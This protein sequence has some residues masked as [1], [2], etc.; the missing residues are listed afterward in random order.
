MRAKRWLLSLVLFL[1][2][3]FV[4]CASGFASAQDGGRRRGDRGRRNEPRAE[5]RHRGNQ[6]SHG[7]IGDYHWRHYQGPQYERRWF[8]R[9]YRD[10]DGYR[11][12]MRWLYGGTWVS[13]HQ[14]ISARRI[15]HGVPRGWVDVYWNPSDL[16]R[17]GCNP[18]WLPRDRYDGHRDL[19][20][21][22]NFIEV[23]IC[24]YPYRR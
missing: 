4:F 17:P 19:L 1:V 12:E 2:A 9:Q 13:P 7:R 6:R 14:R 21:Y 24:Y 11:G 5:S 10:Y 20:G 3:C 23:E 8:P 22:E 16:P 15:V 18:Y